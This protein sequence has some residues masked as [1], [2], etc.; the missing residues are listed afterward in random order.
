MVHY[1]L[2]ITTLS[3]SVIPSMTKGVGVKLKTDTPLRR[4]GIAVKGGAPLFGAPF[5]S[6]LDS[7][8]NAP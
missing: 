7:D 5:I 1:P 4:V 6:T 2:R 3:M 8:S